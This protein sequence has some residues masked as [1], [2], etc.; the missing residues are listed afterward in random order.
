MIRL[1]Y[2]GR[3]PRQPSIDIRQGR[4]DI[5]TH[6]LFTLLKSMADDVEMQ[7]IYQPHLLVSVNDDHA[8][9]W[10]VVLGAGVT[11]KLL[12]EPGYHL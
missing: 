12:P 10:Q 9:Y 8:L 5:Y 2:R 3:Y 7:T 11:V 1:R 4:V 6:T